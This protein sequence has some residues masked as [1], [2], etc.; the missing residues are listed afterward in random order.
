[1]RKVILIQKSISQYR[2]PLF[3]QMKKYLKQHAVD[4]V[5]IYGQP[6]KKDAQRKDTIDLEW[7]T[8]IQNRVWYWGS[9]EIYWQ[10][11]FSHLKNADLVIVEQASRLFA[12]YLIWLLRSLGNFK[13]AFWGHGKNLKRYATHRLAEWVKHQISKRVD[14]WFAYTH[15]TAEIVAKSGFP[16]ERI[17]VLENSID[18]KV[19]TQYLEA[20]SSQTLQNL[21]ELE[22]IQTQNV[23]LFIGGMY[24][25]K[26]ITFLLEAIEY[27]HNDL[28]NFQMFFIGDGIEAQYIRDFSA[29]NPWVHFVGNK[30]ENEKVAYFKLSKVLLLPA[31][32]GLT[33]IDSFALE[34][35]LIT[36]ENMDH[37]PEIEYLS[38][39]VN[40]I[41]LPFP[42]TPRSYAN[43]VVEFL[44]NPKE[45][46]LLKQGCVKSR[47]AY[48]LEN[49]VENFV[50]GILRALGSN[51]A[52]TV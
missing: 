12:N 28:P 44:T 2:K 41:L 10:P 40:G 3:E 14:W 52:D 6:D 42:Q 29:T 25:E 33:V 48:S 36:I 9:H 1:M 18:T 49:M 43:R 8:K 13:F 24:P 34:T 47:D 37:G 4:L 20:L 39:G 15:G 26:Q 16:R 11:V 5:V 45:Q 38:N 27:I 7:G 21:R 32:V 30:F 19:L 17:T 50:Q 31:A 23:A 35:P 22:N 46:T 51:P